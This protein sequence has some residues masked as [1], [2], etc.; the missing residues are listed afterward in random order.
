MLYTNDLLGL[1]AL[2]LDTG[3]LFSFI[4]LL[5]FASPLSGLVA[6]VMAWQ[7]KMRINSLCS[8]EL[9]CNL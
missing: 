6:A 4:C 3:S 5:S 1:C 2:L 8:E 7:G 9:T